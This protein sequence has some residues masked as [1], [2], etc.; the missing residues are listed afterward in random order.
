MRE[1]SD[2]QARRSRYS[3]GRCIIIQP[4]P[5]RPPPILTAASRPRARNPLLGDMWP[6]IGSTSTAKAG[7]GQAGWG[8]ALANVSMLW[9]AFPQSRGRRAEHN[10]ARNPVQKIDG[11]P[12]IRRSQQPDRPFAL[13]VERSWH[14]GRF[15]QRND[16]RVT[17]TARAERRRAG[18]APCVSRRQYGVAGA[19]ANRDGDHGGPGLAGVPVERARQSPLRSGATAT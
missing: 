16:H 6:T 1:R 15:Q 5:A 14:L 2:R 3:P 11:H 19:P 7:P 4:H 18:D 17:S 9:G 8:G 13:S 12:E 10:F